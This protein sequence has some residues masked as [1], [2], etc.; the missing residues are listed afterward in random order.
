MVKG[1]LCP[2]F[3]LQNEAKILVLVHLK[4]EERLNLTATGRIFITQMYCVQ[5]HSIF[6][7][8]SQLKVTSIFL[9]LLYTWRKPSILFFI[10]KY[11]ASPLRSYPITVIHGKT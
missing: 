5:V 6:N 7:A 10:M 8:V 1:G 2:V 9:L 4:M 11:E 3:S